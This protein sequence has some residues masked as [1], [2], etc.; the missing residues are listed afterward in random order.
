MELSKRL[1]AV[2]DLVTPGYTIADV[3]TDHAYIPIYLVEKGIVQRAVA[4]DINEGPL[5]RA[6]EHIKENKLENQIQTRLSNGL[7][8]LQKGE[9]D[10][11]IL[12]GM[13]GNLMIN[14]LN[15]DFNKT[16]S[17]KECILQ[18]QS[19][20][21]KVR[22]FLLEKGFLFIEENMVLDDGKYY[23]MMKVIPPEKI[24]EIKPVFWS[25][26]EIRYGKLLLEEKNP[27]LKQFLERESGIRKDILSKLEQVEGIHISER[28]AELNQELFQIEEGLKYYAM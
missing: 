10:T 16:N 14:I 28:K 21:F 9:V 25:E 20:V 6:T 17:L 18:P 12:A 11:V 1:Q 5:D 2:A 19:E 8:H 27:I 7:Q 26:I 23:P 3:G 4:M 13:G 15:E 24:E 22:T